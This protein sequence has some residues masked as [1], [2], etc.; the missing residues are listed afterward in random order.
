MK[1]LVL[2]NISWA[3]TEEEE[4]TAWRKLHNDKLP[5]IHYLQ[6]ITMEFK[7]MRRI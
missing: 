5:C 3:K 2:R 7:S 4:Y 1:N 6:N